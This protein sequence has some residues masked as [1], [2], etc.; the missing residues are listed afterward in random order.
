MNLEPIIQNEVS[1][2]E[3]NT[4][5][6]LTHIYEIQKNGTDELIRRAVVETQTLKTDLWTQQGKER[7]GQIESSTEKSTLAYVNQI[8][9]GK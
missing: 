5:R 3:K 1:Q 8:A 9:S 6:I 2:K 7:E 4:Y